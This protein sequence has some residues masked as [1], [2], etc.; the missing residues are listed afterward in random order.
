MDAVIERG[1]AVNRRFDRLSP[2]SQMLLVTIIQGQQTFKDVVAEMP[3]FA[4][5]YAQYEREIELIGSPPD[6]LEQQLEEAFNALL[7]AASPEM[8]VHLLERRPVLH[9]PRVDALAPFCTL[10]PSQSQASYRRFV[11][12]AAHGEPL[13][14][15][16]K[17][18]DRALAQVNTSSLNTSI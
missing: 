16:Q 13:L 14:S 5:R 11:K 1:Q 12:H 2:E 17:R 6:D 10:Y 7:D 3:D 18:V 15:G 9:S 8:L 4:E